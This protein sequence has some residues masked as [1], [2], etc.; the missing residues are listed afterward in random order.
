MKT[1]LIMTN[2]A[3]TPRLLFHRTR[4]EKASAS[5]CCVCLIYYALDNVILRRA[6][7]IICEFAVDSVG[8][9]RIIIT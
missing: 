6:A 5:F 3:G 2:F 9:D 4:E 1:R 7:L 8:N